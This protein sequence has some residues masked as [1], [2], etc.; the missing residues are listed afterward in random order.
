MR[1]VY[2]LSQWVERMTRIQGWFYKELDVMRRQAFQVVA[3]VITFLLLFSLA[4][5]LLA[6]QAPDAKVV[7]A[8]VV[9]L[10]GAAFLAA[11]GK[12]VAARI[13]KIGP[14]ELLEGQKAAR[15]LDSIAGEGA[16]AL[17]KSGVVKMADSFNLDLTK[18]E[19]SATEQFYY[20][21]GDKLLTHLK[22][23]GSEP[24]TGAERD[25]VLELLFVVGFTAT[26]QREWL[27]AIRWLRH[28]EKISGAT[29]RSLEVSSFLAFSILF[30]MLQETGEVRQE[31]IR[32]AA[33]RFATLAKRGDLDYQGYFW[34]AYAQ[35]E[36]TQWYE[37][38]RSNLETLKRRPRLAPARY[39]LAL[40]L[41]KLEK[42][43]S[44]HRQLSC[45]RATDEKVLTV[46]RA[47]PSDVEMTARVAAVLDPAIQQRL[48]AELARVS[49]L[50]VRESKP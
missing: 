12:D 26:T 6:K 19:L 2:R 31:R 47:I 32:E 49:S 15:E 9:C 34:L 18:V 14:I 44:A 45:I 36:L 35:D 29:Y 39:N 7:V 27:K 41:L 5:E 1:T 4:Q 8:I 21:E 50:V 33:Q 17:G 11:Y 22:L 42:Y 23:S 16:R 46:V 48:L 10:F 25:V 37:A 20:L 43:S 40:S 24:E 38:V 3:A 28:L 13:K 30:S